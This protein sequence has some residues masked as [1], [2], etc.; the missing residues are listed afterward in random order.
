MTLTKY[1]RNNKLTIGQQITI[2][3]EKKS[4]SREK[5]NKILSSRRMLK[6]MS[7][8][9]TKREGGKRVNEYNPVN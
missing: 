3:P 5:R 8:A 4:E 7:D 1:E 9:G 2:T 6:I